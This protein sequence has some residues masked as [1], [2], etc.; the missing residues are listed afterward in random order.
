MKTLLGV[1]VG[2]A[3]LLCGLSIPLIRMKVP[4][5]LFYGFRIPRTLNHPRIWYAANRYAGKRLFASGAVIAAAAAGLYF[6]PGISV[7]SYSI[8]VTIVMLVALTV[9]VI[10]SWLYL[11]E[12]PDE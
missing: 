9:T 3:L 1:F 8:A 4:P 10:Q 12:L 6:V 2:S 5:N 7:D 11:R